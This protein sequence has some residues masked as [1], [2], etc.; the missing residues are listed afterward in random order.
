VKTAA[1]LVFAGAVLVQ[2]EPPASNKDGAVITAFQKRVETYVKLRRDIEGEAGKLKTTPSQEKISD[3]AGELL[4]RVREARRNAHEGD[5][6]TPDVT[7]EIRRL[8]RLA[9]QANATHVQQSLRHS[10]PVQ[11]HL[12][13]NDKYPDQVPLQSTPPTLLEHLPKLPPEI[14]YRITGRDLV[15]LDAKVNLIIDVIRGVFG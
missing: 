11:L 5:V 9:M 4:H 3:Q 8:I 10:E 2:A 7:A 6:F 1:A 15:L 12:K 14:E 13:V